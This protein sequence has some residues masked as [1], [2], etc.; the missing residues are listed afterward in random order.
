MTAAHEGRCLCGAVRFRAWGPPKWVMWC[1]CDSCRRHS[2]A[3]ASVL[4]P[5]VG[6][7]QQVRCT[8]NLL[9]PLSDDDRSVAMIFKAID[10]V[11]TRR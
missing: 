11:R 2:G 4:P 9:L 1:H 6:P 7:N 3:P 10:F 5:Y 8:E